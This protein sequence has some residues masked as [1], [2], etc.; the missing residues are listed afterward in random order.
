ML[1]FTE[2]WVYLINHG[3]ATTPKSTYYSDK[4]AIIQIGMMFLAHIDLGRGLIIQI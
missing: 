4:I 1:K 3:V 2:N